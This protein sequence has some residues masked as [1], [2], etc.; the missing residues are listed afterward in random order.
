MLDWRKTLY[1]GV[2]GGVRVVNR[3]GLGVVSTSDYEDCDNQIL[4]VDVVPL[5]CLLPSS[6]H[7]T[8]WW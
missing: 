2:G 4:G 5:S 3:E 6:G 8:V 7:L 1:F